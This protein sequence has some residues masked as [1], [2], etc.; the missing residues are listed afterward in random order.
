MKLSHFK[1]AVVTSLSVM[2]TQAFAGQEG[3]TYRKAIQPLWE[4]KC[5]MC[6][7]ASSPGLAE[8]N[9]NKSKYKALNKG[10]RMDSYP[11]L[12]HFVGWPDTGAM[13]RRL[14]DGKHT[15]DG[16]P[17]NMYL[18]LGAN[19]EER[20]N[21]LSVFKGWVSEAG[22]ILKKFPDLTREDL[23]KMNVLE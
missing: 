12:T 23:G 2:V 13:M 7:G 16:K 4:Q 21:N 15:K 11:A 19:E 9:E 3:L 5:K 18:Y 10:P 17:G 20:Q 6:H 22:W 1:M 14:D 8:F